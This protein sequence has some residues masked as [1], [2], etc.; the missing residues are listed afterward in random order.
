MSEIAGMI[1]NGLQKGWPTQE[2][3]K[4]LINSGYSPQEVETEM[5]KFSVSSQKMQQMASEENGKK[6]SNYQLPAPKKQA[7]KWLVWT[8]IVLLI[9]IVGVG[10]ALFL[11]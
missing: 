8:L 10:A 6:L 9:L 2:I 5:A 11:I 7:S 3:S 1:K 4:S